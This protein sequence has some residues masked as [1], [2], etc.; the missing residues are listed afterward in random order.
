M[1]D[2]R[3]LDEVNESGPQEV[4]WDHYEKDEELRQ[5][6]S[7]KA[8]ISFSKISPYRM[9]VVFWL[10]SIVTSNGVLSVLAVDYPAERITGF[11]SDDGTAMLTLETLC[12]T[13]KWVPF[14]RKFNIESRSPESFFF[15]FFLLKVDYLSNS[16]SSKFSKE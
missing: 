4:A 13:R 12:E 1:N 15:F 11:V 5:P 3:Y 16:T 7:R 10:S 6:L 9:V 14:C 2:S 8:P